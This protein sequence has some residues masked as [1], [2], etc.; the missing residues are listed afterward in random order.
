MAAEEYDEYGS[1]VDR[2]TLLARLYSKPKDDEDEVKTEILNQDDKEA[3][4]KEKKRRLKERLLKWRPK[5]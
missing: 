4:Q 1:S 2:I 5:G 3:R